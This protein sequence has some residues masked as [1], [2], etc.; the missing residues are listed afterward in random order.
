[1]A[2]QFNSGVDLN[3]QAASTPKRSGGQLTPTTLSTMRVD[4]RR[5]MRSGASERSHE[6]SLSS[7]T[8]DTRH[9]QVDKVPMHG[10]LKGSGKSM[11]SSGAATDAPKGHQL[12]TANDM[13]SQGLFNM[14]VN[15]LYQSSP[16][17]VYTFACAS[18]LINIGRL[19]ANVPAVRLKVHD[20]CCKIVDY[21]VRK[22][23]AS[24][25][26]ALLLMLKLAAWMTVFVSAAAR[27]RAVQSASTISLAP[28][29]YDVKRALK[30]DDQNDMS[31]ASVPPAET[32]GS[33]GSEEPA[34]DADA[35]NEP[36]ADWDTF[37]TRK[38]TRDM[39][40]TLCF[41]SAA[42]TSIAILFSVEAAEIISIISYVRTSTVSSSL[43]NMGATWRRSATLI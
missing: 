43:L 15:A 21:L 8:L 19:L 26:Q 24:S 40:R 27:L 23:R 32:D 14:S 38:P 42:A 18:G 33:D 25:G 29:V 7:R 36:A 16:M 3:K 2:R 31:D 41:L 9:V 35:S 1:M 28:I 17:I 10:S 13:E 5:T 37:W 12:V 22:Q 30:F 39:I 4:A 6:P 20:L 11:P 34:S